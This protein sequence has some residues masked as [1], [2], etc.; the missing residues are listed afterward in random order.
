M[1]GRGASS[2]TYTW[3]GKTWNY[4][5]EYTGIFKGNRFNALSDADKRFLLEN[6]IKFIKSNG[7]SLSAPMETMTNGRIY[8]AVNRNNQIKHVVFFD[9]ENKRIRQ[10]DVEY[11]N[12]VISSIHAHNGYDVPHGGKHEK[13]TGAEGRLMKGILDFWKRNG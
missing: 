4:G 6:N 7:K 3:R 5:Q 1:G 12:K 9:A 11:E 8:V 2:G 13:L 10:I